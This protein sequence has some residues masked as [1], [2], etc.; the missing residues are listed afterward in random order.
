MKHCCRALM[1]I[2]S[3]YAVCAICAEMKWANYGTLYNARG[4]CFS[5]NGN[6]FVFGDFDS[7]GNVPANKIAYWSKHGWQTPFEEKAWKSVCGIAF[8]KNGYFLAGGVN[9][10]SNSSF[11]SGLARW[12]DGQWFPMQMDSAGVIH[13]LKADKEGNVVAAGYFK[14]INGTAANSIARWNGQSWAPF[15]EGLEAE[16]KKIE[17]DESTGDIYAICQ[18]SQS[19]SSSWVMIWN[20]TAWSSLRCEG[21]RETEA[22]TAAPDGT[23]YVAGER[24]VAG[25]IPQTLY[26]C[27][28]GTFSVIPTDFTFQENI[29]SLVV[30]NSGILWAAGDFLNPDSPHDWCGLISYDGT[31]WSYFDSFDEQYEFVRGSDNTIYLCGKNGGVYCFD[32]TSW[33]LIGG[34]ASW[35]WFTSMAK[36]ISGNLFLAH[37]STVIGWDG[38]KTWQL[39]E[40]LPGEVVSLK[41]NSQGELFAGGN[42]G[43]I[44]NTAYVCRWDGTHWNVIGYFPG[45]WDLTE[46]EIAPNDTLYAV[47]LD[48]IHKWDGEQW[49]EVVD[50]TL[51]GSSGSSIAFDSGG[52]MYKVY[53][54]DIYV[55]TSDEWVFPD[56]W[57]AFDSDEPVAQK[58]FFDNDDVPYFAGSYGGVNHCIFK[59]DNGSLVSIGTLA[60][61]GTVTPKIISHAFDSSNN[62]F[63]CGSFSRITHSEEYDCPSFAKWDGSGWSAPGSGIRNKSGN[64]EVTDIGIDDDGDIYL[65]GYFEKAGGIACNGFAHGYTNDDPYMSVRLPRMQGRRARRESMYITGKT[66]HLPGSQTVLRTDVFSLD[67]RLLRSARGAASIDMNGAAMQQVI[68]RNVEKTGKSSSAQGL[69]LR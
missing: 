39:G 58:I 28:N 43:S 67:G 14:T 35:W 22:V 33:N 56:F 49:V 53:N 16:V 55:R 10:S 60:A 32:D 57:G 51:T 26:K 61:P 20:G 9:D 64:A 4:L 3:L 6:I 46:F 24:N 11:T 66:V 50:L 68:I 59:R 34:P 62:L 23:V 2:L 47:A 19:S 12:R 21:M 42:E 48:Y 36:D 5:P 65:C 30:D 18:N 69:L 27:S 7:I 44:S 45:G 17:I 52:K 37:D 25:A 8:D 41:M 1:M 29:N 38:R 31:S 15:G 13:D 54:G 63:I 40:D